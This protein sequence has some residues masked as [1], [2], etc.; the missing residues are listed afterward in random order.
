MNEL[1]PGLG[2]RAEKIIALHNE[3][4]SM[5]VSCL[6]KAIEIGG[7]LTEQK[8]Q[9]GHGNFIGWINENMP[10]TDR[11]AR[12]YMRLFENRDNIRCLN[13]LS[14]AY[15][16][17][18]ESK[19]ETVSDL[20]IDEEFSK[21]LP[22]LEPQVFDSLEKS[23]LTDGCL[24]SICVWNRIILDGHQ[25]YR[26]CQKHNIP[27][28]T[29]EVPNIHDRN[30]AIIWIIENQFGRKNLGIFEKYEMVIKAQELTLTD[31]V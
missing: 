1:M 25:R 31:K 9:V 23:L 3:I 5:A 13:N 14:D 30:D 6:E 15:L 21:I 8:R 24:N 4:K 7:L 26:I 18:A 28:K 16:M 2:E 29:Y 12:N 19:T 11:T 22:P 27:F 17:L 20:I 10:F